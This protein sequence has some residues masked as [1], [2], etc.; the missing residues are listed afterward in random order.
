MSRA[1]HLQEGRC[2]LESASKKSEKHIKK[3]EKA[4]LRKIGSKWFVLVAIKKL[5]REESAAKNVKKRRTFDPNC[6]MKEPRRLFLAKII[7]KCKKI[8]K[9]QNQVEMVLNPSW[10]FLR[11]GR[12][13]FGK[14][15][16]EIFEA[17]SFILHPPVT[18]GYHM[19]PGD[20]VSFINCEKRA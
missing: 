16:I 18:V 4:N 10:N 7:K 11:P 14:K 3:I 17:R 15:A 5:R 13:N 19:W 9:I 2:L 6:S 12:H 1:D 8:R 20:R